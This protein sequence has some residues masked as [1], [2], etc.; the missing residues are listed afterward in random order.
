[1][2]SFVSA[3]ALGAGTFVV[4]VVW[5]RLTRNR[6]A[7]AALTDRRTAG[8]FG[9]KQ[10][11]ID[12][13][14]I[15]AVD[16]EGEYFTPWHGIDDVGVTSNHLFP[17]FGTRAFL[18]PRSCLTPEQESALL[19]TFQE[20]RG[21]PG[22]PESGP[23]T[24][25]DTMVEFVSGRV[26]VAAV[27]DRRLRMGW[28]SKL[29]YGGIPVAFA[30][31][32]IIGSMNRMGFDWWMIPLAIVVLSAGA[33]IGIGFGQLVF[34]EIR[35]RHVKRVG[36]GRDMRLVLDP[37]R[38]VISDGKCQSAFRWNAVTDV[39]AAGGHLVLWIGDNDGVAVPRRA[40]AAP[41]DFERF[42]MRALT[43]RSQAVEAA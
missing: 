25:S 19:Q 41:E 3:L 17:I 16:D 18:L 33:G 20:S 38:C 22:M 21:R 26:D 39:R 31:P 30:I 27:Q 15:H 7:R 36:W 32:G 9:R 24:A 29:F 37:S 6:R 10:Y 43:L 1:M 12:K 14:G 40:F 35:R 2:E 13:S 28:V 8:L 11:V 5:G 42:A 23:A 34:W 4:L